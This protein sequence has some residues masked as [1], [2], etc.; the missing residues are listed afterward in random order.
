[1]AP[2]PRIDIKILYFPTMTTALLISEMSVTSQPKQILFVCIENAGRGQ[3]AE[4]FAKSM[5]LIASSAGTKPVH[6]VYP[7][8]IGVMRERGLDLSKNEPRLLTPEMLNQAQL[9]ITMGC[10]L[11]QLCPRP[12]LATLQ[13]KTMDWNLEDPKNKSIS[14]VRK[15]RDEIENRVKQ[16]AQT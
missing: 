8:I 2:R 5:G 16:L 4:A 3:M 9:I 13:K 10:S 12:M 15:I 1:M 6:N 7:T 11:E 14:E